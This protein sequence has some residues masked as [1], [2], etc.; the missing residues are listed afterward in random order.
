MRHG[1]PLES[2]FALFC[3]PGGTIENSPA[4]QRWVGFQKVRSPEGTAE[5][6]LRRITKWRGSQVQSHSKWFSRPF[7]TR[8][9]YVFNVMVG[10]ARRAVP[11]HE[12]AGGTY[13]RATLAIEGVA[14]L[15]AARTSQR[16]VPTTLNTY[17][18]KTPG[19]SQDVPPGQPNA[20]AGFSAKQDTAEIG[21]RTALSART[22]ADAENDR[23]RSS[24]GKEAHFSSADSIRASLRRLL[25]LPQRGCVTSGRNPQPMRIRNRPGWRLLNVCD[26]IGLV[27]VLFPV[28]FSSLGLAQNV[29]TKDKAS[30][31]ALFLKSTDWPTGTFSGPKTPYILGVL[32]QNPFGVYAQAFAT[33]VVNG[34][35]IEVKTFNTVEEVKE[36]H[37][38]FVS[39]SEDNN[40]AQI[41]NALQN[42]NVLTMGETDEFIRHGG[43]IKVMSLT[44]GEK[45]FFE[46]NKKVLD[47][48]PLKIHPG[49]L[50]FGKP[51]A[52]P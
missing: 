14:P 10:M 40:L 17:D 3:C 42:S 34:R 52:K 46:L 15:H 9:P 4:F 6:C 26:G 12:V 7:G 30:L 21:A 49:L 35:R 36:C 45:Y 22:G 39:S 47:R 38:L 19:Y 31:V 23:E 13:I 24:R 51:V 5:A 11:V 8:V 33:N 37:L 50:E 27:L 48:S 20:G 18:V 28:L 1:L 2:P 41:Q 44:P 25:Q 32:G 29:S 43:L 16:D